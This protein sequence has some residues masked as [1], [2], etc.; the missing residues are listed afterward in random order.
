MSLKVSISSV[1]WCFL[2]DTGEKSTLVHTRAWDFFHGGGS[3]EFWE[4][5]SISLIRTVHSKWTLIKSCCFFLISLRS[6]I[7]LAHDFK[8]AFLDIEITISFSN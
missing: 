1:E 4:G 3:A 7:N 2:H 5:G 8:S 6:I